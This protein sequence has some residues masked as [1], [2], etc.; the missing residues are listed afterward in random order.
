MCGIGK[1]TPLEWAIVS[2]LSLA[3]KDIRLGASVVPEVKAEILSP[4]TY[5]ENTIILTSDTKSIY[6][7]HIMHG[8]I[9]TPKDYIN[10]L[11]VRY[12]QNKTANSMVIFIIC[13]II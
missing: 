2:G 1:G 8:L 12:T 4:K 10:G 13:A 5:K 3:P 7:Q 11:C 9:I 6:C